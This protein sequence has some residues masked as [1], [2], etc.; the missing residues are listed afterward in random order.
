LEERY[1][2]EEISSDLYNRFWG[3]YQ[4]EK[5]EIEQELLKCTKQMSNLDE[6]VDLS[7]NFTSKMRLKWLSAYYHTRQQMQ[8]LVFPAGISYSKKREG[9]RTKRMNFSFS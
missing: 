2:E 9:C 7:I 3:K 8:F 1:V 6:C 5:Q 4:E